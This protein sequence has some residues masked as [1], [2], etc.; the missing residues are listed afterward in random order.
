MFRL[1]VGG[2]ELVLDALLVP[3][4]SS[5]TEVGVRENFECLNTTATFKV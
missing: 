1:K 4:P 3:N 2:V 5:R